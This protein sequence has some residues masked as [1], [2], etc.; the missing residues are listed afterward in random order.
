[1]LIK[2]HA[3]R[4][5]RLELTAA[6][7]RPIVEQP[8][9]RHI[10]I[11]YAERDSLNCRLFRRTLSR[12]T[13]VFSRRKQNR[14]AALWMYF[15]HRNFVRAHTTLRVSP[16]MERMSRTIRGQSTNSMQVV[17]VEKT[18]DPGGKRLDSGTEI[19]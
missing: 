9:L 2:S 7:P 13:N 3:E 18:H 4:D 8:R 17:Q 12:L 19:N 14:K 15:A 16:A 11:S 10:T 6:Q 1:M 5:G